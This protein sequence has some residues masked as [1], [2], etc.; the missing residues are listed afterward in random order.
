MRT[1]AFT[2]FLFCAVT[3]HAQEFEYDA[4]YDTIALGTR[5]Y[6]LNSQLRSEYKG[7]LYQKV[8]RI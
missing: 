6:Y 3:S 5:D 4:Q 2:I 8:W 7:F 1:I